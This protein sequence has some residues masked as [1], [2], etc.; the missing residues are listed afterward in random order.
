MTAHLLSDAED[1]ALTAMQEAH[2]SKQWKPLL[3]VGDAWIADKGEMPAIA[4]TLYAEGLM[5]AGRVEE[6]VVWAGRA[7]KAI[8]KD[9]TVAKIAALTTYGRALAR[10]GDFTRARMALAKSACIYTDNAETQE[11]QGHILCAISDKWRKGWQLQES[12]L[13]EPSKALPPNMRQWDGKENVPVSVLHEQGIGDAVLFARWIP[14]IAKRTG[15][16]VTWY[17]PK[18]LESWMDGIPGV[19]VGDIAS[20]E[21]LNDAG[22]GIRAMSLPHY[23]QCNSKYDVPNPVAPEMLHTVR[24]NRAPKKTLTVGVCWKGSA[25]GWHDFERSYSTEQFAPVWASLNGVTFVNLC[26]DADIPASAPFA[27]QKFADI[28]DVGLAV[29][30][31]DMV[32]TVDTSILHIAG[33]LGVPTLCLTPTV[34]DWRFAWP[35][36]G[37]SPFYASVTALR[38][39]NIRDETLPVIARGMLEQL[40]PAMV[41]Q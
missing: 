23:L 36:G 32:V 29:A 22:A 1:I 7:V 20:I 35:H 21:H 6:A 11:K 8:P 19:T 25:N 33:S 4:A 16:P 37:T 30:R 12:R 3:E 40:L 41:R 27:R 9:F 18:I 31:C 38:R 2:D 26:H 5:V 15:Q 39:R 13:V 14:L 17:G 24:D 28:Y 10:A 34:A